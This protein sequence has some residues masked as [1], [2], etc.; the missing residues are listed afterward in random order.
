MISKAVSYLNLFRIFESGLLGG[1]FATFAIISGVTDINSVLLIGLAVLTLNF[2][3][4]SWNDSFDIVEDRISH[5]E[6]PIPSGT[7]SIREA[8]LIGL[9]FALISFIFAGLI[10]I[11]GIIMFALGFGIS[12]LYSIF[13]KKQFLAKNLTV[14]VLIML[15]LLLVPWLFEKPLTPMILMFTL[16]VAILLSGYE[17]LKDIRDVEGDI[18]AGIDTIPLRYNL[19]FAAILA[20][21]FF[22]IS[23]LIMVIGLAMLSFFVE[24]FIALITTIAIIFPLFW[25]IQNP[26]PDRTDYTRYT[27]IILLGIA[28]SIIGGLVYLRNTVNI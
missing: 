1:S 17:I 23:C 20:T 14:T 8:Q 6:R 3:I 7:V 16:S 27:V 26:T 24:S 5:P 2:A 19:R 21:S 25:L 22:I 9:F 10:D 13:S 12:L 18:L 15:A 4:V 28:I 11:K